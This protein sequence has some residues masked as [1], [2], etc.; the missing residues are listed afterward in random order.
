MPGNTRRKA[1]IYMSE[2]G[3]TNVFL[4]RESSQS[5]EVSS[6]M[7]YKMRHTKNR[8]ARDSLVLC[9]QTIFPLLIFVMAEKWKNTVWTCEATCKGSHG[10]R[11]AQCMS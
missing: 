1:N 4:S 7:N 5:E 2:N 6:V 3:M 9:G 8:P 11:L 10:G